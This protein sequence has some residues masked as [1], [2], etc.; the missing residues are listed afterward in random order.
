MDGGRERR[1]AREGS[2]G[3]EGRNARLKEA[4]GKMGR[5]DFSWIC[6]V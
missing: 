1:R 2:A 3:S 6:F 5:V 4:R